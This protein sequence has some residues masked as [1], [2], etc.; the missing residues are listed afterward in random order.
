MLFRSEQDL[1]I[2]T[3][4]TNTISLQS[5]EGRILLTPSKPI[6]AT[7]V[8]VSKEE[9]NAALK[10]GVIEA[11]YLIAYTDYISLNSPLTIHESEQVKAELTF[12][13]PERLVISATPGTSVAVYEGVMTQFNLYYDIAKSRSP[14]VHPS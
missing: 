5:V 6:T 2:D 4:L 9:Y 14:Q 1:Q 7:K 10:Q 3:A 11:N 8:S 12:T 13:R